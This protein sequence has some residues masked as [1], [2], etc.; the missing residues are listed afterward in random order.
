[1]NSEPKRDPEMVEID[2]LERFAPSNGMKIL[3][4]GCGDGRLTWHYAQRAS[5]VIGTD[6]E[7]ENLRLDHV[8]NLDGMIKKVSFSVAQAEALPFIGECFDLAIFSWS[9]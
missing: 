9:L 4:I 3:D 6:I 8:N 7:L 5:S 2:F 1:M